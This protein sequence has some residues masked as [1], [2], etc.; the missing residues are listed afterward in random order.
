M[1]YTLTDSNLKSSSAVLRVRG[2]DANSYLQ[3]Q[4]TQDVQA[5]NGRTYGLWLDLKGRVQADGYV[6]K[7]TGQDFLAVS[8]S[9]PAATL[10]ARL[11]AY[12]IADEVELVDETSAWAA[13]LLWGDDAVRQDPPPSVVSF[14]RRR[15]GAGRPAGGGHGGVKKTIAD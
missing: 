5:A 9:T 13:I 4:F 7:R 10:L 12:L 3:G 1:I 6:F 15:A 14:P 8:F 11:E 2:A